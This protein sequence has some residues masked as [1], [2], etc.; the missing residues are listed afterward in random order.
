VVKS[1]FELN[2]G[3][4][5][6]GNLINYRY[7][8]GRISQRDPHVDLLPEEIEKLEEKVESNLR[9]DHDI[10]ISSRVELAEGIGHIPMIDFDCPICPEN[11]AKIQERLARLSL[12]GES[13]SWVI[14]DSGNSYQAYCLNLLLSATDTDCKTISLFAE[15]CHS[16]LD[17]DEEVMHDEIIHGWWFIHGASRGEL[18]MRLT[19]N[20]GKIKLP[21]VVAV[22]NNNSFQ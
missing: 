14:L 7:F 2:E 9:Q 5:L 13:P 15:K 1:I 16:V 20:C 11:L 18:C 17:F 4:I 3:R 8:P 21:E 12:G 6:K 19:N 22:V 10:G